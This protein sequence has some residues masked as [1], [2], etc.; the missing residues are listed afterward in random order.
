M[1]SSSPVVAIVL[2]HDDPEQVRR[3]LRALDPLDVFL[4][5]DARTAPSALAAM[6]AGSAHRVYLMDRLRTWRGDWSLVQVELNALRAA[7]NLTAARHLVVMSGS[8]YPLVSVPVLEA[9]LATGGSR[10]DFY[11][12]P[13]APWGDRLGYPGGLWRLELCFR[14]VRGRPLRLLGR[15]VPVGF[16]TVPS[17]LAPHGGSAWKVYHRDDARSVLSIFDDHPELVRFFRHTFAPEESAVPTILKSPQLVGERA[18][19]LAPMPAWH[20]NFPAHRG[21]GQDG[22]GHADWLTEADLPRLRDA[23]RANGPEG[24]PRRRLFARKCSSAQARL[25][26]RIDAELRREGV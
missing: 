9:E 13:H 3:L 4:H 19:E 23:S 12:L 24:S 8:C 17:V 16:N 5:C 10:L 1:S 6:V 7:L 20:V 22:H 15:P 25:L 14:P 21:E 26:E 18:E 11:P 2:A